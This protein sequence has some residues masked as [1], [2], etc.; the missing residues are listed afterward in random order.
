MMLEK[1]W[2]KV[3]GSYSNIIAGTPR[4][5]FRAF[6]GGVTW[7][8]WTNKENFVEEY[9]KC[10]KKKCVMA[11]GSKTDNPDFEKIGL[12]PG[13]AYSVLKTKDI[14]HPTLGPKKLL[15]MRNPWGE[16]EWLYI[17]CFSLSII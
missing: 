11:S 7:T 1:A 14:N 5:V 3:F 17:N 4:E 9:E 10:V 12:V 13:H 16:R 2:A 8:L 6:T 15:K